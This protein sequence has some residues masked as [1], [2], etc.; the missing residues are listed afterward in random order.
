MK[1]ITRNTL[2]NYIKPDIAVEN[3]V[4]H[5]RIY[6]FNNQKIK[7]GTIVYLIEREIRPYDS[8]ALQFCEKMSKELNLPYKIICRKFTYLHKPKEEFIN[9]QIFNAEAEFKKNGITFE[10]FEKDNKELVKYLQEQQTAMLIIDFNPILDR[11]YLKNLHFKIYEIDSH[12]IIPARFLSDK[13]EYGASTIRRKI[14]KNI[15]PFFTKYKEKSPISPYLQ[16]FIE[17]KLLYYA[18]YRNDPTKNVQSGLSKYLNLGFTSSQRVALEVFSADVSDENKETFFEELIVQM[19]LADNFCLYCSDFK[20]LKCIQNWAKNTILEHKNDIREYIY[21]TN[22]LEE[23][24]T[25]DKLWNAAQKQLVCDGV[26]HGY[27]RMYWAKQI[28]KWTKTAQ[29]ALDVAIYLNDKYAYDSPSPN[30]YTGILWSIGA[31][32]DRAFVNRYITGKIRTMT[33]KSISKKFDV[34]KYIN[35]Y[36]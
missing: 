25:H 32:H 19:S 13:Q 27:L 24:K 26:I 33:Y 6:N 23:A 31:L 16:D 15:Y 11:E 1:R 7:N 30:G 22:A 28:A 12:N 36:L 14:Y 8:F 29:D 17:N 34:D 3:E 20:S 9:T 10:I 35:K 2:L 21:S 5:E 4:K 18:K